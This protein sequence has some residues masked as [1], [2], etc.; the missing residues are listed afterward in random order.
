MKDLITFHTVKS[1]QS[2]L[3]SE[4][5]DS[6]VGLVPTMGALHHGHLALVEKA[7]QLC[8]IVVVSIFVNPTQFNNSSDLEK[9]PRP[10]ANDIE[11]LKK[12]GNVIVFTP[13]VDDM[14]PKDHVA[15]KVDLGKLAN[16]MEGKFRP[17][18]FD[19]VVNV[20]KRLFDIVLPEMAF[21]GLKDF[22]QLAVINEMTN[23]LKLSTI[24]YP[25][26]I[27]REPSGLA[28]SSRN[29]RL[30][31]VEQD[32]AAIIYRVLTE[33]KELSRVKPIS[34]V[35]VYVADELKKSKLELEYFDIV[36]PT[37]LQSIDDWKS[38]AHACLAAFSGDVR[39]ID[40][41]QLR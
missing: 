12:A 7:V 25:C 2:F 31:Q 30:S 16:V 11:L 19:G 21:F 9:Y 28:S 36:D 14:Y 41:M 23:Q 15:A 4:R 29:Y 6:N 40:N 35:K 13:S 18:H 26:Q 5:G 37:D 34:D 22:Q 33:A 27:V 17:G 10:L 39:L 3:I 32:E 8:D 20:V 38:G 24:I 1:L